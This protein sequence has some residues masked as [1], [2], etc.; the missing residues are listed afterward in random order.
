M[1]RTMPISQELRQRIGDDIFVGFGRNEIA[2]R[3]KVSPGLV[4]KVARERGLSFKNTWKVG[5]AVRAPQ[6]DQWV[7]R[8]ERQDELMEQYFHLPNPMRPNGEPSRAEKRLSYAL[9][10]VNRHH[11]GTYR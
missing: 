10:N 3:Y 9:Y 5:T 2:R 1:P 4:S 7:A 6:I 8:V 11:N